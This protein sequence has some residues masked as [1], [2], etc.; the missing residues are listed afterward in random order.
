ME[1]EKKIIEPVEETPAEETPK[2]EKPIEEPKVEEAIKPS[3][4]LFKY[5]KDFGCLFYEKDKSW[6]DA[7][8][9]LDEELLVVCDGSGGAGG[10]KH[11]VDRHQIDSFKEIKE[12]V[13]PEDKE[14]ITDEY[15]KELFAPI[16]E[17]PKEVRTSAFWASRIVIPRFVYYWKKEGHDIEKARAFV[18]Q[19]ME[20]VA[21]ELHLVKS[22]Q[23]DKGLLPT[24]FVAISIEKEEKDK[25]SFDVYWAG[26]SR[27]YYF[28][29][30]GMR[31]LSKDNEDASGS[32]T[33]LFV[34][35]EGMNPKIFSKHYELPKP[36]ALLV[37]S[38]GLFDICNNIQ[39]EGNFLALIED[40]NINS[41]Q[42]FS[43][44]LAAW[45]RPRKS[46]DCTLS[47]KV[48]GYGSFREMKYAYK[49][50][51]EFVFD[52][53]K[54]HY[55]YQ[56]ALAIRKDKSVYDNNFRR[57][58]VRTG[59]KFDDI[60][61]S[62]CNALNNNINDPL[63]NEDIKNKVL[64]AYQD[65]LKEQEEQK[66]LVILEAV[67]LVK[68]FF[69]KNYQTT[70]FYTVFDE[71]KV[72]KSFYSRINSLLEEQRKINEIKAKQKRLDAMMRNDKDKKGEFIT[73]IQQ[74]NY[75]ANKI[76]KLLYIAF[77]CDKGEIPMSVKL[78]HRIKDAD[79][80]KLL[81]VVN[82]YDPDPEFKEKFL[83]LFVEFK[84]LKNYLENTK[85]VDLSSGNKKEEILQLLNDFFAQ[86]E[87]VIYESI[88]KD[89]P[90]EGLGELFAKITLLEQEGDLP[91][92]MAKKFKMIFGNEEGY[93][94]IVLTRLEAE[95][96]K[97][98]IDQFYNSYLLDQTIK[99]HKVLSLKDAEFEAFYKQYEEFNAKFDELL[100]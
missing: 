99:Y 7:D 48:F 91:S 42:E 55:I 54:K 82:A 80:D 37:C 2:E 12:L 43:E 88:K 89:A 63:N 30:N 15:L 27:A 87:M 28:N 24:T 16:Y 40:K 68:K 62:I 77:H 51:C 58:V 47:M 78:N 49:D 96:N 32:I 10:F 46:D 72:D 14:G 74:L 26:D 93:E 85:M 36:C 98:V 6:E 100:K 4:E 73:M 76:R 97:S 66:K 5:N 92:G 84:D 45:Y 39:F 34:I 13:L 59:D 86:D 11:D 29:P 81:D 18:I 8:P 90:V 3:I 44:A 41:L 31:L 53:F 79:L 21:K 9:Y 71:E 50:R 20:K 1:E 60:S 17:N 19:G 52:L 65:E 67:D 61:S 70:D 57:L 23:S 69:F 94:Y 95:N 75:K 22:E 56:D 25:I 38:D 33:N 35:K 83:I 64:K